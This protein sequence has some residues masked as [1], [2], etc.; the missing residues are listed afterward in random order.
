M[1]HIKITMSSFP[2]KVFMDYLDIMHISTYTFYD[3]GTYTCFLQNVCSIRRHHQIFH[4]NL[5][6]LVAFRVKP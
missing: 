2:R 3:H 5:S 6:F 1:K 4:E